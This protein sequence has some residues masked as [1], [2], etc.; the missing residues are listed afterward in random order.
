MLCWRHPKRTVGAFNEMHHLLV[1]DLKY[2]WMESYFLYY[3]VMHH[4]DTSS[5]LNVHITDVEAVNSHFRMTGRL[6]KKTRSNWGKI[7]DSAS[8]TSSSC[9]LA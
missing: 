1:T 3:C 7:V 8:T 5:M 6:D 2:P 4:P 9:S